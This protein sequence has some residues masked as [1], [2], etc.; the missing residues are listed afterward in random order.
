MNSDKY[1]YTYDANNNLTQMF[2]Q[3]WD[4][5]N[6]SWINSYKEDYTYDVNNNKT[7]ELSQSWFVNSNSWKNYEKYDYTYDAANNQIQYLYQ[8]WD[9]V[10]N[11]WKNYQKYDYAYD[12]NGCLLSQDF[13]TGWNASGSYY[14]SHM[15][16][17][18]IN[19]YSPNTGIAALNTS[20]LFV[21][22][23]PVDNQLT[24]QAENELSNATASILDFFGRVIT[25]EKLNPQQTILNTSTLNSGVYFLQ[26]NAAGKRITK[27]FVKN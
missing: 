19:T 13:Y 8:I 16:T 4:E 2:N 26:I 14:E 22:P 20:G 25:E 10:G 11:S 7:Q 3:Q 6:N 18:Y 24:I 17:E 5:D 15:R 21:Y 12:A 23:N 27:K 1:D 9:G